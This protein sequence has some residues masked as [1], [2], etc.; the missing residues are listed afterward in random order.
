VN[1]VYKIICKSFIFIFGV[2]KLTAS[3]ENLYCTEVIDY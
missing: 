2:P 3:A 1:N